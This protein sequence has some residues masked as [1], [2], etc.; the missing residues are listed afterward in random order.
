MNRRWRLDTTSARRTLI[1]L[2]LACLTVIILGVWWIIELEPA[3]L[4]GL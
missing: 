4:R 3:W 2:A 1:V